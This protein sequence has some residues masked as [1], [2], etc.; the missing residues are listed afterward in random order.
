MG[1]PNFLFP[2]AHNGLDPAYVTHSNIDFTNLRGTVT[3]Y[4]SLKCWYT[5]ADSMSNKF[6][7]LK[8]TL[9]TD[10]P[11]IVAVTEVNCKFSASN[12]DFNIDGYKT[13]QSTTTNS[14]QRGVCI[15]INSALGAFQDDTLS[16]SLFSESI[17]C[18]IPLANKNCLLFGVIYRS[19]N[20]DISNFDNLCSLLT[21]AVNTGVSHLLVAGDFNMPHINW[22]T[23][24][25]T[26]N[27]VFDGAFLTLLDDL[28]ITQHITFP[29]RYRNN[30][31]PSVLD[32]ILSIDQYA[33]LN[34]TSL[35]PLGKSDHIVISFEFLC[36]H[37]V[38][39]IN[40][41]KYLYGRGDYESMTHE[42]L[43]V[44]WAYLF[45]GQDIDSMWSCFHTK[46]LKLIDKYIPIKTFN[47]KPKPKWLDCST[48]K[49]IKIKHE[50][51]N[52]YKATGHHEDFISYTKYRNIATAVVK[53]AKQSFET[54]LSK[55][56][57][58]YPT[59]FWKYVRNNTK[60]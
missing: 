18:W 41:P 16:S 50:A 24:S 57:Q 51:W 6:N 8:S 58:Q 23:R 39:C 31:T 25:V 44:D 11:D 20:S 37:S 29:T 60:V 35:P 30:Q 42:L 40:V 17:W 55:D 15:F 14:H 10:K 49:K 4:K 28:F 45:E 22:S 54:N 27:N 53:Y 36:Y 46:L 12:V 43:N 26:S 48:L 52:I 7:E 38:E 33:V 56:I 59:L 21:Q 2:A 19:P 47:S 9:F 34:V 5:N 1:N 3:T 13:I 32:L